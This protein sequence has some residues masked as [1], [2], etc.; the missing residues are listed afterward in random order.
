MMKPLLPKGN[1]RIL[2]FTAVRFCFFLA[3]K[4]GKDVKLHF[5]GFFASIAVLQEQEENIKWH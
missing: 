1:S 3:F 5:L 4:I 2:T